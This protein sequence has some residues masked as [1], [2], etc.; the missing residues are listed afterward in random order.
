MNG[1]YGF[2]ERMPRPDGADLDHWSGQRPQ[3]RQNPDPSGDYIPP[4][5]SSVTPMTGLGN[6]GHTCSPA[7]CM[8][9]M[10][11]T[12]S[13]APTPWA[14]PQTLPR[15]LP[16]DN[17]NPNFFA[18]TPANHGGNFTL[19]GIPPDPGDRSVVGWNTPGRTAADLA[20]PLPPVVDPLPLPVPRIATPHYN[21]ALPLLTW[22]QPVDIKS[23]RRSRK[24]KRKYRPLAWRTDFKPTVCD[25][26]TSTFSFSPCNNRFKLV[27]ILKY[28]APPNHRLLWDL[29]VYPLSQ[30]EI[31]TRKLVPLTAAQLYRPATEPPTK[32]M[33]IYH[34]RLPW[35]IDIR[36]YSTGG[37]TVLDVLEQ[38]SE[39]LHHTALD[40]DYGQDL[41]SYPE[42]MAINDAARIR[43]SFTTARVDFLL[44]EYMFLGLTKDKQG[45]W[46]M[47]TGFNSA[48]LY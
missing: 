15:S 36:E 20:D 30:S 14:T 35:Y 16:P 27:D 48:G 28:K 22:S 19:P 23:P 2:P 45:R 12:Q 4:V 31:C 10:L 24:T 13:G 44:H 9:F 42:R 8:P 33:R 17:M 1:F 5:R 6:L 41:F 26:I 11:H 40:C 43:Y 32:K 29:R 18:G 37:I 46:K 21:P 34:D 39:F 3:S 38:I 25:I 47:K 7:T